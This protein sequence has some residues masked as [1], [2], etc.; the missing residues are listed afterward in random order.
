MALEWGPRWLSSLPPNVRVEGWTWHRKEQLAASLG[1]LAVASGG[2]VQE[3]SC[4][5]TAVCGSANKALNVETS[6]VGVKCWWKGRCCD[7][8]SSARVPCR[9]PR[10]RTRPGHAIAEVPG[11]DMRG[12]HRQKVSSSSYRTRK[13][14]GACAVGGRPGSGD[15][16]GT[17]VEML[18]Q[19][20]EARKKLKVCFE[21]ARLLLRYVCEVMRTDWETKGLKTTTL[22]MQRT[23]CRGCRGPKGKVVYP[24][25]GGSLCAGPAAP[26]NPEV[27][28]GRAAAQTGGPARQGPRPPQACG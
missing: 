2:D 28:G 27:S 4:G 14:G 26:S 20:S 10:G 6:F 3:H 22:K 1:V 11:Q 18:L 8:A 24:P 21:K 13:P 12:E 9:F 7:G 25:A 16:G 15:P 23:L 17:L 19:K 5:S